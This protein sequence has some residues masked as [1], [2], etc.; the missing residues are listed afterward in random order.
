[1]IGFFRTG[2]GT[3]PGLRIDGQRSYLRPPRLRDWKPWVR[4]REDSRAFLAPWEPT[5]PADA[6]TRAAYLRRL[7][8]QIFEWRQDEGYSFLIFDRADDTLLGGLGF[9]NIRRGVAQA[10]SLG[11]WIGER[12]SRKGY[13]TDAAL[14][15]ISF[16]FN[17]LGLHRIEA[18]C[19]PANAASQRLL[20]RLGFAEEGYARAYLK[21]DGAWRDHRL[22]ALLDAD[23]STG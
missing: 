11:Y 12:H 17:Q 3:L 18:A 6:L 2:I 1:M 22:Y 15:A 21:I 5:W 4:L 13:M 9:S 20:A 14:A 19:L 10:A 23:Y 7:R 16:G 8:R